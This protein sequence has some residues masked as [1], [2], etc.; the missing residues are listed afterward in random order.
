MLEFGGCSVGLVGYGVSN[1]AMCKYLLGKGIFPVVR[2]EE[3]CTVPAGVGAV[4]G[5]GYLDTSEDIVFRSPGVRP[6][7]I[8]GCGRVFTEA[9]YAL[10]ELG[11]FKIGV[12]GSDGKTTTSTLIYRMLCVGG[13]NAYLCGNIG[14]PIIDL[15]DIATVGDYLVAELSSFQLMDCAPRLDVA[16]I[17]NISQN[18]LDWHRD[19]DEYIGAKVNIL[20][21][22]RRRVLNYDD[23]VLRELDFDTA[24]YFSLGERWDLVR[25]GKRAIH[26]VNGYVYDGEKPLFP[27]ADVK[28]KGEYN[29]Q[30][31]LCATAC[32]ID[33]VDRCAI[34]RVAC[35]FCGVENRAELVGTIGGVD[36]VC[37]AIDTTPTRTKK[38]LSAFDKGRVVC[39]LGGYDKNL[40]YGMLRE[41]IGE[42][43]A[44]VICGENREKIM[45]LT[46]KYTVVNTLEE[47][48]LAAFSL[49]QAGDTVLL[50]PASASFDMFK[51]YKEKASCFKRA[52]RSL[53]N[54][55][56]KE[57]LEGTVRTDDNFR[58]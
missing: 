12:S 54:G 49:A 47:A 9:G 44:V 10:E 22:A 19:M 34:H 51:N 52:V 2:C 41:D 17:T 30:N 40:D 3:K 45:A 27:V 42:L 13:K 1:R 58:L 56:D 25:K 4:F 43:K 32:V 50:S 53:T 16:A 35:E 48:V 39:I 11:G 24:V 20:K 31:V 57:H 26:I 55:K 28:L 15:A 5:Q 36:L 33:T 37:S 23:P 14:K 8:K 18:H 6:D 38:T 21:N 46:Q 7:A 29:L